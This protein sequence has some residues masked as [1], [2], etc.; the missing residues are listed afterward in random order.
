M[1]IFLKVASRHFDVLRDRTPPDS[2]VHKALGQTTPIEH[3]L[4]GVEFEGYTIPCDERQARLLLEVA[5]SYCPE[6]IRDIQNAI[7]LA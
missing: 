1:E 3:S 6:I 5:R 2:P 4:D 7:K